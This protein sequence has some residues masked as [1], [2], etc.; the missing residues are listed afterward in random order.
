MSLQKSHT[1]LVVEETVSPGSL[2]QM[3]LPEIIKAIPDC[4][5]HLSAIRDEPL[6][7]GRRSQLLSDQGL[8]AVSLARQVKMLVSR[9][10]RV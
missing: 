5:F 4:Q 10:V 6:H 1:L 2:G 3:I 8:D 9:S 7:Q